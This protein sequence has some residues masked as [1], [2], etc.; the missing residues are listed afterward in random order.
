MILRLQ[1]TCA[2]SRQLELYVVLYEYAL[3]KTLLN[4]A[5]TMRLDPLMHALFFSSFFTLCSGVYVPKAGH[6]RSGHISVVA[7]KRRVTDTFNLQ[8]FIYLWRLSRLKS[9]L[10]D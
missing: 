10:H 4:T 2:P 7:D 1:K 3:T 8:Q 6:P 5:G 9:D